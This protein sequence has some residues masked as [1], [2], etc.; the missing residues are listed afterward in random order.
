MV[1]KVFVSCKDVGEFRVGYVKQIVLRKAM[2]NGKGQRTSVLGIY[3]A[4]GSVFGGSPEPAPEASIPGSI[5]TTLRRVSTIEPG[6]PPPSETHCAT[7]KEQKHE[8]SKGHPER[9]CSIGHET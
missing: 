4:T 6:L 9:R 7:C 2:G 8:R 1:V 5:W 3:H